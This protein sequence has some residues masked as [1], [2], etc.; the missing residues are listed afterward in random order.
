MSTFAAMAQ[1]KTQGILCLA[2]ELLLNVSSF[3]A[4]LE[5]FTSLTSTCH[6]LHSLQSAT[7][8]TTIFRLASASS[9]VFFRPS[10]HF[11]VAAVAR[12]LGDWA[13]SSPENAATLKSTFAGGIEAVHALCLNPSTGCGLTMQRIRELH[14]LRFSTVDPITDLIYKCVGAQFYLS[15]NLLEGDADDAYTIGANPPEAFFHLAIFGGIFA[16]DFDA[17]LS[18]PDT[19]AAMLGEELR[20]EYVKYCV[21]DWACYLCQHSALDVRLEDGSMDPRRAAQ[22]TTGPYTPFGPGGNREEFQEYGNQLGLLWLLRSR[23]FNWQWC[24]VLE[25]AWLRGFNEEGWSGLGDDVGWKQEMWES[26][27]MSQGLEGLEILAG[28]R[29]RWAGP[30]RK[31]GPDGKMVNV[32]RV[33]TEFQTMDIKSRQGLEQLRHR[34]EAVTEPPRKIRVGRNWTY[35]YPFPKGDL[36]ICTSGY[37]RRTPL[38]TLKSIHL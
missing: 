37:S 35:R 10:P 31:E 8:A 30:D 6:A 4:N 23:R 28:A 1:S 20:L 21:P 15:P 18:G 27:V 24:A 9:R 17:F 2:P 12:Q 16:G 29:Q 26:A 32:Q 3:L 14:L 36:E 38:V 22:A 25:R 11:L 5:D 7:S 13:R 33:E 19:T 34:I